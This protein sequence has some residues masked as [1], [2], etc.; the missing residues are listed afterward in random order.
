MLTEL[1]IDISVN[2]LL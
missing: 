1:C 2:C